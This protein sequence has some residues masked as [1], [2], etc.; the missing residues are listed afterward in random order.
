MIIKDIV[1]EDFINYKKPS[2]VIEFPFCSF[3]CDKEYGQP[4]CQNG[5]LATSPNIEIDIKKIVQ[6]YLLNPITESVVAQGLEPMDSWEELVSFIREFRKESTDDIVI[7]TGYKKE[8]VRS[9]VLFLRQF[10]N[11]IIKFGRYIP[12]E[13]PHFDEVLGVKL[14]SNNQY[15]ERIS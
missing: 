2:M 9:Q 4:V 1:T 11:I 14:A 10:P 8:E 15:A 13:K 3:K 12:N 5:T 6:E 7:Y